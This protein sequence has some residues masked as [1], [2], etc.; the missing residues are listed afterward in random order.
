MQVDYLFIMLVYFLP[1][2]ISIFNPKSSFFV[3][4][5]GNLLFSW[6]VIFWFGSLV[7]AFCDT[8]TIQTNT[9]EYEDCLQDE[10]QKGKRRGLT[11][12]VKPLLKWWRY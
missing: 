8:K 9:D 4:F 7:W 5:I 1:S 6:T 2:I 3:I 10:S 11:Q 12:Y